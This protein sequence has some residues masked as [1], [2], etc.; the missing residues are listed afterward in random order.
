[1]F[2]AGDL[3][4][5]IGQLCLV[6]ALF[7]CGYLL[8]AAVVVIRYRGIASHPPLTPVP[9]TVLVPLCGQEPGLDRRLRALR[10]QTYSAPVQI[11][12]GIQ[13]AN[14]PVID[15]VKAVAAEPLAHPLEFHVDPRLHGR[16]MKMSNMINM[17]Q[18][19]QHNTF[20]T[21]DSDVEI[22][23]HL[24]ATM[25]AELQQPGVGA[26]SSLYHGIPVGG[27]WARLAALR[28]NSHFLPNVVVAL[29]SGL[30]QP[31]FG[32]GM[33]FSRETLTRIGGFRAFTEQLWDDYAIGE[34][35][36]ALG[37]KVV[38][39]PI[40]LGHVYAERSAREFFDGQLRNDR[41]I[42]GLDPIGHAGSIVTHPF[43]LALIALLLGAG[44]HAV[45][46]ALLALACRTL[47]CWCT[48]RRFGV[49]PI[50]YLLLP[51][52]DL[53]S[54]AIFVASY[55]GAT[56]MWRGHRYRVADGELVADPG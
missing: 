21:V 40:S 55:F 2:E 15:V 44:E 45:T 16:N 10:S 28:V 22:P 29:S 36:R 8:V 9:V 1:M 3:P 34:A 4:E 19:A 5:L 24:I 7:G 25:V 51:L 54:F 17:T 6:V 39:S 37:A 49:Q 46:V 42:R 35:V 52:R 38:M 27:F 12:C 13:N 33:A 50:S 47:L 43:P 18:H 14:D 31:C 41:T 23:P 11:I 56:V 32:A 26:V 48:E 20:V 53:L 30:A